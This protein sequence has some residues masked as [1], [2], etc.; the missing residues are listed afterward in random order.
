MVFL[1]ASANCNQHFLIAKPTRP[2]RA[3]ERLPA[4][5]HAPKT[6]YIPFVFDVYL[7]DI[8]AKPINYRENL[9][10]QATLRYLW[11]QRRRHN[12]T[13]QLILLKREGKRNE[14]QVPSRNC[15]TIRLGV[16]YYKMRTSWSWLVSSRFALYCD[17][18]LLRGWTPFGYADLRRSERWQ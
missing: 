16:K 14:K 18:L 10:F 11:S 5:T 8:M 12:K 7:R 6:R 17:N 3:W 1:I 4:I 13:D 9:W 15:A 2:F